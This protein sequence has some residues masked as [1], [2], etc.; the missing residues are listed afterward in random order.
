M[1]SERRA[2]HFQTRQI[3]MTAITLRSDDPVDR[4]GS[5]GKQLGTLEMVRESV[6]A[7]PE[8][9]G[10][11][12]SDNLSQ[13]PIYPGGNMMELTRTASSFG[14]CGPLVR[15]TGGDFGNDGAFLQRLPV[16]AVGRRL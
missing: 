15:E 5:A 8:S 12:R 14:C 6:L 2:D 1:T 7:R 9:G 3:N 11:R 10:G 16:R 4:S 13:L